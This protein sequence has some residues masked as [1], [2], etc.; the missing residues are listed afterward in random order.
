M[1]LYSMDSILCTCKSLQ[2]KRFC[3]RPVQKQTLHSR[4]TGQKHSMHC[5]STSGG[6]FCCLGLLINLAF[7]FAQILA[8]DCG[9]WQLFR[10]S[11]CWLWQWDCRQITSNEPCV[12]HHCQHIYNTRIYCSV[13]DLC[14]NINAENTPASS[15]SACIDH[16]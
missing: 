14:R 15:Q 6:L 16:H 11:S 3:H 7:I 4:H 5:S 12:S 9:K 10:G 13:T 2:C 8:V 1:K